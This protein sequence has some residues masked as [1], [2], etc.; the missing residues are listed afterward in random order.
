MSRMEARFQEGSLA[1]ECS[2]R[3]I[4][5]LADFVQYQEPSR[6]PAAFG[7]VSFFYHR[8]LLLSIQV[9]ACH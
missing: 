8:S 2:C 6:I 5:D 7:C 1:A 3:R 4:T 9:K